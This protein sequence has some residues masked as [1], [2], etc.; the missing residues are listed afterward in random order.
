M[1]TIHLLREQ[2]YIDCPTSAILRDVILEAG[3]EL[4]GL[5]G[6]LGNCGGCGQCSTC[7]V[8]VASQDGDTCLTPRTAP[9]QRFLKTRP[10]TWRLACQA[11]VRDSLVVVTRPQAGWPGGDEA[12]VAA[13]NAM[14]PG[15]ALDNAQQD[16]PSDDDNG[17]EEDDVDTGDEIGER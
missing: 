8:A 16:S 3:V 12:L 6:K 17:Q 11:V 14:P 15:A 10:P 5:K 9:E 13:V 7:F 4:Y 1:P 2:R